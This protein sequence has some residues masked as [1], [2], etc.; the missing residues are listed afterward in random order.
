MTFA[1]CTRSVRV[2]CSSIM[3]VEAGNISETEGGVSTIPVRDGGEAITFDQPNGSRL[4]RPAYADD[5][6]L[7]AFAG[8]LHKIIDAY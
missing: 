5:T 8:T 7:I 1:H 2:V 6:D 3:S 4:D